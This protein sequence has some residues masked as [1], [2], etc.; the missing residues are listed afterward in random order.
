M[1]LYPPEP[2]LDSKGPNH[3]HDVQQLKLEEDMEK[4]VDAQSRRQRL[5]YDFI[6]FPGNTPL[7]PRRSLDQYGHPFLQEVYFDPK[8]TRTPQVL[9]SCT[10]D[11]D[12]KSKGMV[13]MVDQLWCWIVNAGILPLVNK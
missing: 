8:S 1:K 3:D 5:L 11:E 6:V 12:D 10:H 2:H 7:H 9:Y 4:Y 13:L